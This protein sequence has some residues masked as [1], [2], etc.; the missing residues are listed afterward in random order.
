MRGLLIGL[1]V[2][3]A[4]GVLLALLGS[5]DANAAEPDAGEAPDGGEP[6]DSGHEP[7]GKPKG[8]LQTSPV[9]PPP[10]ADGLHAVPVDPGKLPKVEPAAVTKSYPTG[11]WMYQVQKGDTVFGEDSKRSI[12]YRA[13]LSEAYTAA[14][15][16]GMSDADAKAFARKIARDD[17]KRLAYWGAVMCVGLNDATYGTFGFNPSFS[18]PGPHGRSI[19]MLPRH[20]DNRDRVAVGEPMLRVVDLQSGARIESGYHA[21]PWILLPKL[22]ESSLLNGSIIVDSWV[23][24][25]PHA[26][27]VLDSSL[28]GRVWGC[29]DGEEKY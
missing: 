18:S 12:V 22:A 9:D 25:F 8:G 29:G 21:Y 2:L 5:R 4:G 7:D 23:P 28:V 26:V 1:G 19:E 13:L 20:A 15:N 10:K 14:R 24:P 3:G 17:Q 27:A 16:V 6:P 11:G